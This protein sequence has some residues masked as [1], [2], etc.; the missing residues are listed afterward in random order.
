MT[1]I[2]FVGWGDGI[3]LGFMNVIFEYSSHRTKFLHKQI[4]CNNT[5]KRKKENSA[6]KDK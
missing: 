6:N 4:N 2:S 3:N 1:L 5:I